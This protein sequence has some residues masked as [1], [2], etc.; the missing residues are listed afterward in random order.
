MGCAVPDFMHLLL[1]IPLASRN[2]Y[3]VL[4]ENI[5]C[6]TYVDAEWKL[7]ADLLVTLVA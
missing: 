3:E 7:P 5:P 1:D 6:K 4:V 2:A